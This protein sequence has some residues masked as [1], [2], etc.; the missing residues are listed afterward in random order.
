MFLL[1]KSAHEV[2]RR[3]LAAK[4]RFD[5]AMLDGQ[6][7]VCEVT[8][9]ELLYSARNSD[10]YR[11]VSGALETMPWLPTTNEAMRRA[12]V[13]QRELAAK[14]MHRRPIPDLVIAATAEQHG[15]TV[16]HYDKDFD[17]IAEVTGQPV[18]WIVPRGSL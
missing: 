6:L 12:L 3:D 16:L 10:D 14:G 15:A 13:V 7:A 18:E 11:A 4:A 2:R 1:D 8:V 17:L 9:L 5:Q